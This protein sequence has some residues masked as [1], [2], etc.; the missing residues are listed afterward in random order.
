MSNGKL[1]GRFV[2]PIFKKRK[3]I[4]KP[5]LNDHQ[6]AAVSVTIT[7]GTDAGEINRQFF[8]LPSL[9]KTLV[10]AIDRSDSYCI[11]ACGGLLDRRFDRRYA[12]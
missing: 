2:K 5:L 6:R 4:Q 1:L 10:K 11:E 12:V 3:S 9:R 7:I 8:W